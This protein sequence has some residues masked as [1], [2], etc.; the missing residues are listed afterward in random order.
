MSRQQVGAVPTED[1]SSPW[2]MQVLGLLLGLPY[3]G[4]GGCS[5][6]PSLALLGS[7]PLSC[8]LPALSLF[9]SYKQGASHRATSV[10]F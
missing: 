7:L 2:N 4:G 6:C 10:T 8:F 3:S 5:L 9:R 1:G